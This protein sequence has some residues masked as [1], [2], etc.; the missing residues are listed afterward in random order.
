MY[1]NGPN[2]VDIQW[3]ELVW[4]A[5]TVGRKSWSDVIQHGYHSWLEII[6][7]FAILKANLSSSN[8]NRFIKTDAY[9]NLDP[10]EKSAIS[11]FLGLSFAKFAAQRLLGIPWLVHLDCFADLPIDLKGNRRPDLIGMNLVGEWSIFEAKGRTNGIKEKL[12]QHAKQQTQTLKKIDD[13]D[14]ALRVASIAYF[15]DHMLKL[16]LEDPDEINSDAVD[17]HIPGGEEQ[18]FEY[19]YQPFRSLINQNDRLSP[20]EVEIG[21]RTINA[22]RLVEADLLVGLDYQVQEALINEDLLMPQLFENRAGII[23][24]HSDNSDITSF[25]GLDGIFVRLG[26]SWDIEKM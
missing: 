16:R 14:P 3:P 15:S 17:F 4:A 21:G 1:P 13:K 24:A 22:V 19:Y 18:F 10:S 23:Q 26:S 12:I 25:L 7:R 6:Y 2:S 8:Q 5:I 20:E 11:Y 9:K